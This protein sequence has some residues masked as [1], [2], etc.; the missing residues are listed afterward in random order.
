MRTLLPFNG[1]RRISEVGIE[2]AINVGEGE[3]YG[4][5]DEKIGLIGWWTDKGVVGAGG[6]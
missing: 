6:V 3:G 2:F 5:V 4:G 1:W